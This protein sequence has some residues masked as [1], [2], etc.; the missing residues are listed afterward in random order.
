MINKLLYIL[1]RL[2]SKNFLYRNKE[3][4][5]IIDKTSKSIS[6]G[7]EITDYIYLYKYIKKFKPKTVLECGT[8]RSTFIIAHTMKKYCGAGS[9]LISMES[10]KKYYNA[11]NKIFPKKEFPFVKITYSPLKFY[12]YS[13]L[14]GTGYSKIPPLNYNFIFIDGPVGSYKERYNFEPGKINI[15]FLN[16]IL[17]NKKTKVDGLIDNRKLTVIGYSILFGNKIVKFNKNLNLGFINK[18]SFDNLKLKKKI[19]KE[20]IFHDLVNTKLF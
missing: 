4:K 12:K 5:E 20:T 1:K 2:Y 14:S 9:K 18:A 3:L 11:Q 15:D 16:I 17:K 7:T 13:L 6:T 10:V 19:Y 8:G